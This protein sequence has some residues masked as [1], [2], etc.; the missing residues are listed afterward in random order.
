MAKKVYAVRNGRKTGV[1]DSWEEC[2]AQIEGYSG[3]E[4][5]GFLKKEEA[6]EFLGLD[7]DKKEQGSS[8]D[9]GM[10]DENTAIAYVDGSY[11]AGSG[12][13]SCGMVLFYQN[14]EITFSK[15]FHEEEL[16]AMRNV[17]GELK[18]A[19]AAMQY[20]KEHQIKHLIIF[21]DY[22]GIAKWCNGAWRANKPGTR[23]YQK[24]Y[25]EMAQEIDI[26]FQKVKGHSGDK[27]NDRADALARKALGL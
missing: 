16:A 19:E 15:R 25:Q 10:R 24:F 13:F 23:A 20:A 6:E 11:H 4:Y 27:Y 21:H 18:G 9:D 1:F 26:Q 12:D 7:A 2:R 17:A 14:E 8:M 5:K 3:A 22:E